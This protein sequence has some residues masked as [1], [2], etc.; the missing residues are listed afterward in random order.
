MRTMRSTRLPD[1][2]IER[3][4]DEKAAKDF[5]ERDLAGMLQWSQSKVAQKLSGRTPI[6]L[7]ELEALCVTLGLAPTE[8]VRDRG[9]E[10]CAELTPLELRMIERLRRLPAHQKEALMTIATTML[11]IHASDL[12]P[13]GATKRKP[14]GHIPRGRTDNP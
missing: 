9:V 4:K 1:R 5:S 7:E 10:F 8:A 6:T 2:V 11:Q 3:L 13:R 12:E 14:F